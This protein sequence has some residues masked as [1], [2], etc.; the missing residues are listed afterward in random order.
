MSIYDIIGQQESSGGLNTYNPTST[1][2]GNAMGFY[3]I[4]TG[5]WNDFAPQAGVSLDQ[6]PNP[7]SAPLD[8]QTQVANQIPLSRWAGSTVSAVQQQ[9]PGIDTSQPL[10]VLAAQTGGDSGP[11]LGAMS[12]LM[13][14]QIGDG[15][16]SNSAMTTGASPISPAG[17][18]SAAGA[19]ASSAITGFLSTS[20]TR[21][22][23]GALGTG[24]LLV[25]LVSLKSGQSPVQIVSS[26]GRNA[27]KTGAKAA[28]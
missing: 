20:F 5:T 13:G 18:A 14:G 3:Q 8:V 1:S 15:G 21:I 26:A 11:D 7:N 28:M 19:G 27:L 25:G 22:L 6:F 24:I 9:F 4:T 12:V 10:G 17:Q 16:T 23:I 2:S